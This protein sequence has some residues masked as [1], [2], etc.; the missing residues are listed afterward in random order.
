MKF[1][2]YIFK[3]SSKFAFKF[4]CEY[5]SFK[6]CSWDR[7]TVSI[8]TKGFNTNVCFVYTFSCELCLS[9]NDTLSEVSHHLFAIICAIDHNSILWTLFYAFIHGVRDQSVVNVL[10][11]TVRISIHVDNLKCVTHNFDD[12]YIE[13]TSSEVIDYN[14]LQLRRHLIETVSYRCGCRL[15]DD[16]FAI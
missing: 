16:T 12:W 3:R 4:L 14:P 8:F 9:L 1:K 6:F 15:V 13:G 5:N 11:S 10:T 7:C 2:E